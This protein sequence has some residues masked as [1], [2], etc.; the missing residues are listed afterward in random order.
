MKRSILALLAA[1]S[2]IIPSIASPSP[3]DS[4]S[5]QPP[6]TGITLGVGA[7]PA[8][9]IPTN[10]FL[11]QSS[12]NSAAIS[13]DLRL[14]FSFSPSTRYGA[15]YKDIYQGIGLSFNQFMP[16]STLGH[17]VTA[18]L[19]QGFRLATLTPR[20]SID[21][22]WNFG[23]SAGWHH[24][25]KETNPENTA[26]GSSVN[27][28]L[29]VG[30]SMV[31]RISP[32]WAMRAGIEARHYSNGNTR[33]P[34]SGVNTLG[35]RIGIEYT[36]DASKNS[37]YQVYDA[38]FSPGI[39]YDL[40]VYGATR[41]RSAYDSSGEPVVLPGSFGVAGLNFAPMYA[42]CRYFR[43]GVSL[44]FQYDESANIGRHLVENTYGDD[45]KF[46]RQPFVECFSAG[47]SL[48]A[49]LTLPV[50]SINIGFGRNVAA[51]GA[52]TTVFYQTLALKAYVYKNLF[53]QVGYRL[54]DFHLPDNLMLGAGYSIRFHR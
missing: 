10:G 49:E 14:G 4:I 38:V 20:L 7:N 32:Q 28:A 46:Y 18:Y 9:V 8:W 5:P 39:S 19:F 54:C 45:V 15:L 27:A 12:D 36:F 11:R 16:H 53:L 44:D 24:Y 25:D 37:S 43:A 50:F 47:L 2:G 21:G 40:T 41:R 13:P 1:T 3:M 33:L 52:D 17:P 29:G 48:R 42:V 31:Y 35:G 34:N 23:I 26:I 30:L 51:K 22:E 6:I